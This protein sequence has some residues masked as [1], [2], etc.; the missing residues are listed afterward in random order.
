MHKEFS[1]RSN[2]MSLIISNKN[3]YVH[4]IANKQTI[5]LGKSILEGYI[6]SL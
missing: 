6:T 4:L 5:G 1:L 3:W 2:G